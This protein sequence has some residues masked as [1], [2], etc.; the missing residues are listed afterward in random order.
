MVRPIPSPN[1]EPAK[2]GLGQIFFPNSELELRSRVRPVLSRNSEPELQTPGKNTIL[3]Q[4]FLRTQTQ[5][6]GLA[7]SFLRTPNS[8]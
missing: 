3:D 4:F 7:G 2:P 5:N 1:S 8:G 6:Q